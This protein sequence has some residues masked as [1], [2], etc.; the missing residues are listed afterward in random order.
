MTDLVG[1]H[2]YTY[3]DIS[4]LTQATHPSPMPQEQFTYDAWEI[5]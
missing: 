2:N 5:G 3:D 1:T 4:E